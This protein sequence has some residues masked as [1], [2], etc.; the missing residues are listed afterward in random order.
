MVIPLVSVSKKVEPVHPRRPSTISKGSKVSSSIE[1][2]NAHKKL[3]QVGQR[4]FDYDTSE[5]LEELIQN[6]IIENKSSGQVQT[7]EGPRPSESKSIVTQGDMKMK[8]VDQLDLNTENDQRHLPEV[9]LLS[10]EQATQHTFGIQELAQNPYQLARELNTPERNLFD[11][12]SVNVDTLEKEGSADPA[13]L[14]F[15]NVKPRSI[16]LKGQKRHQTLEPAHS[17]AETDLGILFC[18]KVLSKYSK[19]KYE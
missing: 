5:L 9:R 14:S 16:Q 19:Q 15:E 10:K 17:N 11:D 12:D 18:R 13:E 3:R 8:F 4:P 2:R 7:E 1:R 6:E